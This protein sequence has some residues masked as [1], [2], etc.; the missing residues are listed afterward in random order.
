MK[1]TVLLADDH[2]MVREA[3]RSILEARPD[4]EVAGEV[5]DGAAALDEIRKTEPD[6]A[7]IDLTMPGVTG[8]EVIRTLQRE[9]S[10]TRCIAFSMHEGQ[11]Q[12]IQA[13]KA[14]AAGYVVKS[15]SMN[16][17]LEAIDAVKAG[18]TFVAPV[19][20][21]CVVEATRKRGSGDGGSP[22]S[23]LTDR[24]LEVLKL[25]A[26]GLSSKEIGQELGVSYKT[27]ETHRAN[28]MLKLNVKKVSRLVRVAIQEGLV[29][30]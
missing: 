18:K 16:E 25:I 21:H 6:L 23:S 14:G 30:P 10:K 15:S 8:V 1:T 12:V 2:R 13:L 9:N 29:V 7:L 5:G 4:L 28:L 20:A 24:E 11:G 26:D 3:I 27:I 19:V 22:F 17:L